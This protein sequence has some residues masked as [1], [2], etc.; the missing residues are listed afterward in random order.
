MNE[1]NNEALFVNGENFT[2][3]QKQFPLVKTKYIINGQNPIANNIPRYNPD[4]LI[5]PDEIFTVIDDRVLNNIMS[6][7]YLI[8]TYGRVFDRVV[9]RFIKPQY[10]N[11][12]LTDGTLAPYYRVELNYYKSWNEIAKGV[13]FVHR[14]V[15]LMFNYIENSEFPR[16]SDLEVNHKNS[17]RLDPRL[18]NLEIITKSE[19]LKHSYNTGNRNM[20][21]DMIDRNLSKDDPNQPI[22]KIYI[23][24]EQGMTDAKISKITGIN[25]RYINNLRNGNTF[26]EYTKDYNIPRYIFS[27]IT[28]ERS[29]IIIKACE[30]IRDGYCNFDIEQATGLTK[31]VVSNIRHKYNYK[32][33]SDQYF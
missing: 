18:S 23:M 30:M 27:G 3:K 5:A 15:A 29:K 32:S 14:A 26:Q 20:H 9:G 25:R 4:S 11:S 17:N 8:S 21:T 28:E 10:N 12:K 33:I 2:N 16:L 6:G 1:N 31:S 22:R 7:R 13:V 24:M 19:N